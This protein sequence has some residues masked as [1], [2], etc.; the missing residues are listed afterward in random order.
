MTINCRLTG[1]EP[2]PETSV[3][4]TSLHLNN[5]QYKFAPVLIANGTSGFV[6]NFPVFQT[7]ALDGGDQLHALVSVSSGK[8]PPVLFKWEIM[9]TPGLM[10]VPETQLWSLVCINVNNKP[11]DVEVVAQYRVKEL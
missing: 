11:A 7:S 3:V 4:V 8:E 6:V 1:V 2:A 10:S 9:W 5:G